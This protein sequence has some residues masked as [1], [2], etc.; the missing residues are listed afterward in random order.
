MSFLNDLQGKS[1]LQL[2]IQIT[3][4]AQGAELMHKFA[5]NYSLLYSTSVHLRD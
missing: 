5:A 1:S 4:S 3:K 2:L